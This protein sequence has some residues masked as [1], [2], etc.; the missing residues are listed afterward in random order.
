MSCTKSVEFTNKSGP[1]FSTFN[2]KGGSAGGMIK[3]ICPSDDFNGEF[4]QN[5]SLDFQDSGLA[6]TL[7]PGID[8]LSFIDSFIL[9]VTMSI[10]ETLGLQELG[11]V[12]GAGED[13][14]AITLEAE[15][16]TGYGEGGYGQ[17][18]YGGKIS[19]PG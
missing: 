17:L 13:T 14:T 7:L 6:L 4:Q 11:A 3:D 10:N 12:V 1:S 9:D 19:V 15:L 8:S 5:D 16:E 18:G 2:L